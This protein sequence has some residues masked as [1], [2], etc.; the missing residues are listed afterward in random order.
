MDQ[1]KNREGMGKNW[2]L[3]HTKIMY[4]LFILSF[5]HAI[6]IEHLSSTHCSL[7]CGSLDQNNDRNQVPALLELTSRGEVEKHIYENVKRKNEG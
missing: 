4:D 2:N 1:E 6:N 3:K 5:I 7:W